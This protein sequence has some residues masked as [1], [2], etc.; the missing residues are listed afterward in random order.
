MNEEG[1][2]ER[3]KLQKRITTLMKA[4]IL[5]GIVLLVTGLM[6]PAL[7]DESISVSCYKDPKSE[8]PVGS[9]RV[10][11]VAEAAQACNSMYYDCKGKCIGCYHDFDYIDSVCVDMWGNTFLK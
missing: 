8:W 7:A 4:G 6:A 3:N 11:D 10:Y 5:S 1:I 2:M 9:A